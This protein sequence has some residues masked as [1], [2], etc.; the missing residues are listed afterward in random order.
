MSK[1]LPYIRKAYG[2]D[3]KRGDRVLY[4]GGGFCKYGTV[5]GAS[6]AYLNIRMDGEKHAGRYHPTWELSILPRSMRIPPGS[7]R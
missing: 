4:Q 7:F 6:D 3:V 2:L 5:T 1:C